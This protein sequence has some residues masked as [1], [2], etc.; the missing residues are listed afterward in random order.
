MCL[1]NTPGAMPGGGGNC[2]GAAIVMKMDPIDAFSC[3]K[4]VMMAPSLDD[5]LKSIGGCQLMTIGQDSSMGPP[6]SE[7]V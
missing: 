5:I 3:Y 6:C 2:P 4:P 1:S 7:A